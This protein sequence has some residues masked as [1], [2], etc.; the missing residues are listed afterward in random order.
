M[1]GAYLMTVKEADYWAG[2]G[3]NAEVGQWYFQL[4]EKLYGEFPSYE[5]AMAA[6]ESLMRRMFEACEGGHCE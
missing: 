3:V 5:A 6:K 1:E 2:K 4:A